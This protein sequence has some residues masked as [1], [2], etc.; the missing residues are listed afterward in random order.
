MDLDRAHRVTAWLRDADVQEALTEI[1]EAAVAR[2]LE[3]KDATAREDEWH[4]VN[5]LNRLRAKLRSYADDLKFAEA[6]KGD[7]R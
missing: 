4:F 5:A 2:W 3:A 6:R 7:G 1:E